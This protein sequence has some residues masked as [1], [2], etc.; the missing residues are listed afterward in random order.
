MCV[1]RVRMHAFRWIGMAGVFAGLVVVGLSDMF[2][3]EKKSE[4]ASSEEILGDAMI[5]VSQL[6]VACQM[7]YEQKYV[8]KYDVP[9][10]LAV[11]LEGL[12]GGVFLGNST[13]A[14]VLHKSGSDILQGSIRPTRE[15]TFCI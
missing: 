13:C 11:G 2:F 15:H 4:T 5:V 3:G 8:M 7:V 9:A 14:Y 12:F 10:L 1:L 6:I